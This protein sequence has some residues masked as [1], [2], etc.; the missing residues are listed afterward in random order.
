MSITSGRTSYTPA[1]DATGTATRHARPL[2]LS[3]RAVLL[4]TDGS[5]ASV[6]AAHVAAALAATY[7]AQVHVLSV[8]DTRSA[9]LPPPLDIAIAIGDAAVGEGVHAEQ[10]TEVRKALSDVLG[11]EI[12]WPVRVKLGSPDSVIVHEARHLGAVLVL[13][14]LRRHGRFER[15][16][17]DETALNVMRSASCPVLGV[18]A[19]A[20]ELPTRVLAAVDFSETSLIAARTA[21]AV[22][23]EGAM[24]VLAYVPPLSS[25]VPEDGE[26]VIHEL[27]VQAGFARTA[28]ELAED[29]V[30]FDH[31]VLHRQLP[32]PTA[33]MLLEYAEGAK[34][35]LV[36]AG[37]ARHGR[38]DRWMLG[39]VSTDLVR[40][41]RRSV[42]IV[43]PGEEAAH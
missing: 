20:T 16:V 1:S 5:P 27:G 42:L 33:E 23:G 8:V 6:A 10:E 29:G 22:V 35:D 24:L 26:S 13:V 3:G 14:G 21:C 28:R 41:G 7:H 31:V 36:A 9:P 37:S 4:A 39:S 19:G 15:A 32:R 25:F 38:L 40:D 43:P 17:Q 11:R 12:D 30:T 2:D 34:I 18:V